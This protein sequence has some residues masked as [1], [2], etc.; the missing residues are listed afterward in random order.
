LAFPLPPPLLLLFC[1]VT[2]VFLFPGVEE[3]LLP[4]DDD[5]PEVEGTTAVEDE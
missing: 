2:S 4:L 1:V 5:E 3:R